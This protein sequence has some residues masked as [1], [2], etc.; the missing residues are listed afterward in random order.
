MRRERG[1]EARRGAAAWLAACL[2]LLVLAASAEVG[3]AQDVRLK[4]ITK[5]K[6]WSALGKLFVFDAGVTGIGPIFANVT[7]V[8]ELDIDGSARIRGSIIFDDSNGNPTL[9]LPENNFKSLSIGE[10]NRGYIT[11]NTR[12]QRIESQQ[13]VAFTGEEDEERKILVPEERFESLQIRTFY[14]TE[15]MSLHTLQGMEETQIHTA[16]AVNKDV[17]IDGPVHLTDFTDATSLKRAALEVNGGMSVKKSAIFGDDVEIRGMFRFPGGLVD[18]D[19]AV[20]STRPATSTTQASVHTRGGLAVEKNA[21]IGGPVFVV[22][23]TTATSSSNASVTTNGGLGVARDVVVDGNMD[24]GGS[25]TTGGRIEILDMTDLSIE[26]SGGIFSK[27]PID[28]EEALTVIA[29]KGIVVEK[30]AIIGG[31]TSVTG[32]PTLE[33]S[34]PSFMEWT[35]SRELRSTARCTSQTSRTQPRSN[36]PRWRSTAV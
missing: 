26:T 20:A 23:N 22:D 7:P 11:L 30:D 18:S 32:T 12:S 15:L 4:T 3:F 31:T 21:I 16:L 8:E 25:M 33:A 10:V 36:G 6:N 35:S 17:T 28:S 13:S 5:Q 2:A 34:F 9:Q 14:G 24:L 29:P 27:G 19:F 1:S